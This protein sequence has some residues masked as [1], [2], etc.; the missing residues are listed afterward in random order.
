MTFSELEK[1]ISR[2]EVDEVELI[3]NDERN[4]WEVNIF[5]KPANE[6]EKSFFGYYLKTAMRRN[7]LYQTATC[8]ITALRRIGYN[9]P[10]EYDAI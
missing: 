1:Y 10:I 7:Y 9:G 6:R 5:L 4:G 8:A 2:G 3:Y